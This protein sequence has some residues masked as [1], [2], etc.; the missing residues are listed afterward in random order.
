MPDNTCTTE[1]IFCMKCN[2]KYWP[3]K[4]AWISFVPPMQ[5]LIQYLMQYTVQNNM[6]NTTLLLLTWRNWSV[7]I[8]KLLKTWNSYSVHYMLFVFCIYSLHCLQHYIRL[9]LIQSFCPVC[10]VQC[11]HGEI[12]FRSKFQVFNKSKQVKANET[13]VTSSDLQFAIFISRN[14]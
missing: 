5:Y 12:T 1:M 6:Q 7:V 4:I 13:F 2:W 10:K 11:R 14:P 9:Y 8:K 3:G